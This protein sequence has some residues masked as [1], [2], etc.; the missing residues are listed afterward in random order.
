MRDSIKSQ[1]EDRRKRKRNRDKRGENEGRR[2]TRSTR[3]TRSAGRKEEEESE[4]KESESRTLSDVFPE[5]ELGESKL[6]LFAKTL[7]SIKLKWKRNFLLHG[8][9]SGQRFNKNLAIDIATTLLTAWF[10]PLVNLNESACQRIY[11]L[12]PGIIINK[13]GAV[14]VVNDADVH[15]NDRKAK[16][17]ISNGLTAMNSLKVLSF[18]AFVAD[19]CPP[20]VIL[21]LSHSC[22]TK[23]RLASMGKDENEKTTLTPEE[24]ARANASLLLQDQRNALHMVCVLLSD[25]KPLLTQAGRRSAAA[26][27]NL[28]PCLHN[29]ANETSSDV[30]D[31]MRKEIKES[32]NI[33]TGPVKKRHLLNWKSPLE[34]GSNKS[35]QDKHLKALPIVCSCRYVSRDSSFTCPLQS[36][37]EDTI[38]GL[39][40]ALVRVPG[41]DQDKGKKFKED[42]LE[43][44]GSTVGK[45]HE[46]KNAVRM[47]MLVIF[48]GHFEEQDDD[49]VKLVGGNCSII[50]DKL[51]EFLYQMNKAKKDG[52]EFLFLYEEAFKLLVEGFHPCSFTVHTAEEGV[53][54][55]HA[56]RVCGPWPF[57]TD[58]PV[59]F[60]RFEK[61]RQEFCQAAHKK[62]WN[63]KK[64]GKWKTLVRTGKDGGKR[65]A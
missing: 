15:P 31:M 36:Q 23:L 28:A 8:N 22:D 24:K 64:W 35:V 19:A 14:D 16:A 54:R 43:W 46:S 60:H 52:S 65:T 3:V 63:T 2:N 50:L 41:K 57:E 38:G 59:S 6:G 37:T 56:Q 39:A 34:V 55:L 4:E 44:N 62:H 26:A 42:G 13:D 29:N 1:Q 32:T 27:V 30:F 47:R 11:E 20:H 17:I 5:S 61:V 33:W 48:R 45:A 49:T 40:D 51:K 18:L 58:E 21:D 12:I 53:L 9:L 25:L 7:H 10:G